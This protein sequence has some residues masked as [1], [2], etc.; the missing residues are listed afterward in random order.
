MTLI[1]VNDMMVLLCNKPDGGSFSTFSFAALLVFSIRIML[2]VSSLFV[3][4]VFSELS[5]SLKETVGNQ[6]HR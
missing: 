5:S 1:P 3:V 2:S 6:D 4:I